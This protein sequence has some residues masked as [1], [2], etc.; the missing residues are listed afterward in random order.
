MTQPGLSE[1]DK[2]KIVDII[3][4]ANGMNIG[5]DLQIYKKRN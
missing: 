1:N 2:Q 5:T 3:N 4:S